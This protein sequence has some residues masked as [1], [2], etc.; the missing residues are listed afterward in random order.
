MEAAQKLHRGRGGPFGG[1]GRRG[2]GGLL[3]VS[4]IPPA[5]WI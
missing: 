5:F 3:M 1:G 4:F 2:R